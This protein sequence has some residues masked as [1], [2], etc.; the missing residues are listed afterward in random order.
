MKSKMFWI[1]GVV[2]LLLAVGVTVALAAAS[3]INACV[4]NATGTIRIIGEGESCK[5]NELPLSW[6]NQE[7]PQGPPGV[8]G[9]YHRESTPYTVINLNQQATASAECDPGDIATGGGYV[10][11][12]G[13]AEGFNVWQTLTHV[14]SH[15][16]IA[17]N[18]LN[19]TQTFLA[20][21][22]CADV[23]P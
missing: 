20:R 6:N 15:T 8:L 5:S 4:K 18:N 22:V 11:I 12:D 19:E 16:V 17:L 1:G 14:S 9:F 3:D 23:T 2:V 21:V 13:D 7:G 10:L